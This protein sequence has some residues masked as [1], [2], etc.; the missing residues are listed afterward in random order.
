MIGSNLDTL[1]F[2]Y[3]KLAISA[4]DSFNISS[5]KLFQIFNKYSKEMIYLDLNEYA[6]KKN[7]GRLVLASE[8]KHRLSYTS[9]NQINKFYDFLLNYCVYFM[10]SDKIATYHKYFLQAD[11]NKDGICDPQEMKAFFNKSK[12]DKNILN[13][14][15]KLVGGKE[16]G[17]LTEKMFYAMFQITMDIVKKKRRQSKDNDDNNKESLP[18]ELPFYLSNQF[19]TLL[20][21]SKQSYQ[22]YKDKYMILAIESITKLINGIKI[23]QYSLSCFYVQDTMTKLLEYK[24]RKQVLTRSTFS[25]N[26]DIL[27]KETFDQIPDEMELF[28]TEIMEEYEWLSSIFVKRP[29]VINMENLCNLFSKCKRIVIHMPKRLNVDEL[30]VTSILD[31]F[32]EKLKDINTAIEFKFPSYESSYVI[33]LAFNKMFDEFE[34]INRR[35]V[36]DKTSVIIEYALNMEQK[37]TTVMNWS[38]LNMKDVTDD[39]LNVFNKKNDNTNIAKYHDLFVCG[40]IHE[41]IMIPHN[42][43]IPSDIKRECVKF[44]GADQIDAIFIKRKININDINNEQFQTILRVTI[45]NLGYDIDVNSASQ[46]AQT[47]NFDGNTIRSTEGGRYDYDKEFGQA[48]DSLKGWK[49]NEWITIYKEIYETYGPGKSWKKLKFEQNA[50][51]VSDDQL[52]AFTLQA[53]TGKSKN[54][55]SKKKKKKKKKKKSSTLK[56]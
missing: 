9:K 12:L 6:I 56:Q 47:Q 40:Y 42:I 39:M 46:I 5:F 37:H 38:R 49:Q 45:D 55:N 7:N 19:M 14:I 22:Q 16:L 28:W 48:F 17:H 29:N 35:I 15:F 36:G 8:L 4:K 23:D 21:N 26:I 2:N 24:L 31:D 32:K 11:Q 18:K 41:N 34:S 3:Y 33:K 43:Y 20:M 52:K 51:M 25:K 44:V 30:L 13:T 10:H 1:N 27:L 53:P 50:K 54:K